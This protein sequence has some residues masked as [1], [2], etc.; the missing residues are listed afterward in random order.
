MNLTYFENTNKMYSIFAKFKV[1]L[2][3][4]SYNLSILE[5]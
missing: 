1:I 5:K 3:Q 4:K 2:I